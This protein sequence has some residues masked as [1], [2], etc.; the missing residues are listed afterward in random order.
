[1]RTPDA[2]LFQPNDSHWSGKGIYLAARSTAD[3]IANVINISTRHPI[4]PSF[5]N[6]S[7]IGDLVK[8]YNPN[9]YFLSR[10][11]EIWTF[12]DK[13]MNGEN[14]F[15]YRYAQDPKALV[16]VAG[17]SFTGH[18]TW[19]KNQPVGFSWQL[20]LFLDQA[21]VLNRAVAGKGSFQ[22]IELFMAEQKNLNL[23][24]STEYGPTRPKV[25]VW[26]FPIRDV[27][28]ILNQP[29]LTQ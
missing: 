17:T 29:L 20:A 14:G 7:H 27:F 13:L 21:S 15:G 16:V 10:I 26:E 1:M 9:P 23:S 4:D 11:S 8:A 22:T 24:F 25:L 19:Q 12:E 5:L 18:Q 6:I 3:T 2:I 28:G